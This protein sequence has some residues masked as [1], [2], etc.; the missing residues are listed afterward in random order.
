MR[1]CVCVRVRACAFACGCACICVCVCVNHPNRCKTCNPRLFVVLA[2]V[3]I[4]V[5]RGCQ[6]AH[7]TG[8]NEDASVSSVISMGTLIDVPAIFQLLP[9]WHPAKPRTGTSNMGFSNIELLSISECCFCPFQ[10]S[11]LH[12]EQTF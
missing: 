9:L 4:N 12:F 10:T 6:D 1:V 11:R 3:L 8:T 2:T 5:S 7:W